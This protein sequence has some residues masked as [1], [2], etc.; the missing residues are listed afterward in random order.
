[1]CY[2]NVGAVIK[3]QEWLTWRMWVGA[4]GCWINLEQTENST[5]FHLADR[6]VNLF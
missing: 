2:N 3:E 6:P 4:L 5:T 1:M